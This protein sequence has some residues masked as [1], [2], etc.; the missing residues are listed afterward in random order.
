MPGIGSVIAITILAEIGD[1]RRFKSPNALC[2]W[3]GLTPKI[4]RSDMPVRHGRIS[5]QG[6]PLLRAAMTRAATIA[7]WTS[8]RWY[9]IHE[10]LV[11]R[12]GKQAAKVAIA[13]RLLTV[14]YFMLKNARPYREI[15]QKR[16][17]N[18][19]R[20]LKVAWCFDTAQVMRT[21]V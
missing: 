10:G 14:G 20:T 17:A 8:K 6:S 16:Q 1:I 7:S 19:R 18:A 3:A 2:N 9:F 5:K 15:Y 12:C 11:L 13:R 4:R 21:P